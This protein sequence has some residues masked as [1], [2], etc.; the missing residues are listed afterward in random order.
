M[1]KKLA[2]SSSTV[3]VGSSLLLAL[4]ACGPE[5]ATTG[6]GAAPS[7]SA[8]KAPSGK[9][10]ASAPAAS[11]A[12]PSASAASS[13]APATSGPKPAVIWEGFSTPESVVWDEAGDRYLV[14]NINGRPVD[15]D[16][17][18]FISEL[19]PEGKVKTL[20]WIEGGKNGAKLNAPKGLVLSKDLLFVADLDTVRMFDSKTGAPKGEVALAGATFVNDLA[21]GEDGT[22]YA[23]DS[24]LKMEGADFKPS[25]SDAVWAIKDGKATA[26][27][28]SEELGRP[29]GLL[30]TDVGLLVA[31]FGSGAIY[32]LD[33]KGARKNEQKP[34]KGSLDGLIQVGDEIFVSSWEGQT[35]Y[36][37]KLGDGSKFEWT[38]VLTGLAAPADIGFDGKR[39]RVLV[40]RFMDNVVQAF[41]LPAK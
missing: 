25:G 39:K 29:N 12:S 3:L 4:V 31:T 13:S 21:G 37:S 27:G 38:P 15:A 19:D 36:R 1:S 7:G 34:P 26:V 30:F 5:A 23:S 8:A 11:A 14:S 2:S 40:P 24:G 28:K 18:G 35:V 41:D 33:E 20:K 17:N 6:S 10:S 32:T 9:T 22:V 16:G